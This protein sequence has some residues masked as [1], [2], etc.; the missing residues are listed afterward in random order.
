MNPIYKTFSTLSGFYVYDR[1]TNSIINIERNEFDLLNKND[2]QTIIQF[3][4]KGYMKDNSIERIRHLSTDYLKHYLH[5]NIEQLTIQLTQNCN[6][7]CSYCPYMGGYDNRKYS[8]KIISI[9]TIRKGIDFL[10]AHSQNSKQ[11]AIG[12]Y[13]GEPLLEMP[14]L[15]E[16]VEYIEEVK[17]GR[18]VVL[19]LTTNGTLLTDDNVEFFMKKSFQILISLDGAKEYHNANRVFPNGEGSFDV[20]MKKLRHIKEK[21]PTFFSKLTINSVI[22]TNN[23]LS[24]SN[25][26]F[27]ADEVLEQLVVNMTTLSEHNSKDSILYDDSFKIINDFETCKAYLYMIGKI[28]QR[29]VSKLYKSSIGQVNSIYKTLEP[30]EIKEK[31]THP[32]GPCLPGV[33]R[34]FMDVD[35]NFYPCERVSESSEIMRIGHIDSGIDIVKAKYLLNVGAITEQECINCFAFNFCKACCS[36]AD[37]NTEL[38]REKKLANC[39]NIKYSA[40]TDM[41]LITMLKKFNYNFEES[42]YEEK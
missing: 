27:N 33:S 6:L 22:S 9:E 11:I 15:K 29:H 28:S 5:N 4:K 18:E 40:L 17:E 7:R 24:C 31:E 1:S 8:N 2:N 38:S 14:L 36:S 16:A 39:N 20:I 42:A 21:Y 13:G 32:G 19:T 10:F 25:D 26:F 35:G 37:G 34:L 12:F 3:K 30:H 41:K 23:D